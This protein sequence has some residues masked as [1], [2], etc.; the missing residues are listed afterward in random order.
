MHMAV[1]LPPPPLETNPVSGGGFM[2]GFMGCA[3]APGFRGGFRAPPQGTRFQGWFQGRFHGLF[4]CGVLRRS[5]RGHIQIRT[6]TAVEQ[7]AFREEIIAEW[8]GGPGVRKARVQRQYQEHKDVQRH[9]CR[10]EG[11]FPIPLLHPHVMPIP[12]MGHCMNRFRREAGDPQNCSP[13]FGLS[14]FRAVSGRFQGRF[15]GS[16]SFSGPVGLQM[17]SCVDCF[18]VRADLIFNINFGGARFHARF[19]GRFHGP[20]APPGFRGGFRGGFMAYQKKAV[21]G[22]G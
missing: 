4:Y 17:A 21:S 8:R 18:G 12:D 13:D 14:G 11:K 6:H 19:H 9:L 10:L 7:T 20:A 3:Q 1:F 5:G 22:G 16:A 2:G 15:H